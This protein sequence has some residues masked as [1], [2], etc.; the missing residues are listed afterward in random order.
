MSKQKYFSKPNKCNHLHTHASK[1]EATRCNELY[2]LRSL[3]KIKDLKQQPEFTLQPRFK[4]EGKIIRP[5]K[6]I[7]DFS[8][9]DN[10]SE[11]F[12]VEDVKGFRTKDYMIKKKMLMYMMRKRLDFI[13]MET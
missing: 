1:K 12:V 7:A 9:F 3:G 10:Q 11:V 13:F 2:L 8:Y 6:Y 4:L 5:I